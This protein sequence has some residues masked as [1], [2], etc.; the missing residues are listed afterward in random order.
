MAILTEN[1]I[2]GSSFYKN[3]TVK[4]ALFNSK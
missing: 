2:Y 3:I 4:I 1:L